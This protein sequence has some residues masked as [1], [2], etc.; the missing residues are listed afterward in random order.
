MASCGLIQLLGGAIM[1]G[2]RRVRIWLL[3]AVTFILV[4][5]WGGKNI[6][7]DGG[8]TVSNK[9]ELIRLAK[10]IASKNKIDVDNCNLQL[11]EENDS[12]VVEFWP[13]SANQLGGGGKLFFKKENSK[14]VFDRIELWQ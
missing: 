11:H 9:D 4:L 8:T 6:H 3:V 13:K 10:E 2:G 7:A 12:T 1:C 5:T 14:Y